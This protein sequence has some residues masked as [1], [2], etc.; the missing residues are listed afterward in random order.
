MN[1]IAAIWK[2][3]PDEQDYGAAHDFLSLLFAE[4]DCKRLVRRL[5]RAPLIR[6]AA[7][8]I[9]RAARLEVLSADNSHVA[10]DLKKINRTRKISPV[11][12]VRGDGHH[13]ANLIVADGYHRICASWHWL[14]NSPVACCLVSFDV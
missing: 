12:L 10:D 3:K 7:K 4:K 14:E 8:D 11:L 2:A 6:R 1:K 5:R 9:L 13:G